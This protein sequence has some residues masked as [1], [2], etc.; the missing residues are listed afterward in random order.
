MSV[1]HSQDQTVLSGLLGSIQ[2]AAAHGLG[3]QIEREAYGKLTLT[4]DMDEEVVP[5]GMDSSHE[6]GTVH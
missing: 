1:N 3:A 4:K 5:E 2:L 6:N